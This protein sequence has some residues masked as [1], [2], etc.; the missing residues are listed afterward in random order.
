MLISVEYVYL[1][2]SELQSV[3]KLYHILFSNFETGN[4]TVSRQHTKKRHSN[5][6]CT[7]ANILRLN[8]T[9]DIHL[10]LTS[11]HI[12]T[13]KIELLGRFGFKVLLQ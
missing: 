3:S 7:G 1:A 6:R 9:S 2:R 13:I 4:Q 11:S 10:Y 5:T 12:I 8:V